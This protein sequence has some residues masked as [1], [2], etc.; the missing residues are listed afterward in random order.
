M[1]QPTV[2]LAP[3]FACGLAL[4]LVAGILVAM[5][6]GLT[7][8][9]LRAQAPGQPAPLH[10]APPHTAPL[11][12]APPV[13]L[14]DRLHHPDGSVTRRQGDVLFRQDGTIAGMRQGNTLMHSDGTSTRFL[15]DGIATTN[16]G[17]SVRSG[18]GW[19]NPDGS[20]TPLPGR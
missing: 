10:G 12:A 4:G 16:R 19:L 8:G 13:Q 15:G 20:V 18:S 3:G 2:I 17:L 14:G 1:R 9:E 6:L 7:P 11:H 5:T